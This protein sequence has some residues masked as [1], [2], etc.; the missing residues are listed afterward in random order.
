[1]AVTS[2]KPKAGW[3]WTRYVDSGQGFR[4]R[5]S[6]DTAQDDQRSGPDVDVLA[7]L[8]R[9]AFAEARLPADR[10][11]RTGG[12]GQRQVVG[13]EYHDPVVAPVPV[14]RN[15]EGQLLVVGV[16]QHQEAVVGDLLAPEI[17]VGD[18]FA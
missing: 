2:S 8:H 13:V 3:S 10:R 11:R 9:L 18:G 7:L 17:G 1:M 15:G 4:R 14:R 16:E 5:R 12:L 6:V